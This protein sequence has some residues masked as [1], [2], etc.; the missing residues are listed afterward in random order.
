MSHF[1]FYNYEDCL[2]AHFPVGKKARPA[3]VR[4]RISAILEKAVPFCID[5][6]D[7]NSQHSNENMQAVIQAYMDAY[8]DRISPEQLVAMEWTRQ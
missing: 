5:F 3:Y 6:E 1:A 7:F 8:Q 2:P 4:S